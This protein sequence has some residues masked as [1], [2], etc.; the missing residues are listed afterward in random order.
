MLVVCI[1]EVPLRKDF[2]G[3]RLKC[4]GEGQGR[5]MGHVERDHFIND[6]SQYYKKYKSFYNKRINGSNEDF[7]HLIQLSVLKQDGSWN[8]INI[9]LLKPHSRSHLSDTYYLHLLKFLDP[10]LDPLSFP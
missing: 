2:G 10:H 7:S 6:V 4:L 5:Y 3:T 1:V 8:H 9:Y